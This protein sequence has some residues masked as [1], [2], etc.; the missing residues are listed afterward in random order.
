MKI[1]FL[2]GSATFNVLILFYG[3]ALYLIYGSCSESFTTMFLLKLQIYVF[4]L[5]IIPHEFIALSHY[6]S[7]PK[8]EYGKVKHI[9]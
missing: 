4:H 3:F 6:L 1:A 9:L 8:V 5:D 2:F 7:K